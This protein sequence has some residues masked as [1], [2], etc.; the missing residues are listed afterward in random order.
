MRDQGNVPV[1]PVEDAHMEGIIIMYSNETE[2]CRGNYCE[3]MDWEFVRSM[4]K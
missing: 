4:V 3:V 2:V 1:V